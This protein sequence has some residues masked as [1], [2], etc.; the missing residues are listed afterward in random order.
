MSKPFKSGKATVELSPSRIRR[1]PVRKENEALWLSR[2][3]E[4]RLAVTGIVLFAIGLTLLWIGI[5]EVTQNW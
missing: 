2:E 3:W 5:A 1:D 4:N